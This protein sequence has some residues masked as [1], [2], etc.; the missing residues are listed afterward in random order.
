MEGPK[1]EILGE[2]FLIS[3]GISYIWNTSEFQLFFSNYSTSQFDNEMASEQLTAISIKEVIFLDVFIYILTLETYCGDDS[4][5]AQCSPL[6]ILLI[7]Y[8]S[9]FAGSAFF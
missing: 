7:F 5:T 4:V 2:I 8:I 9:F 1:P 3:C 6:L